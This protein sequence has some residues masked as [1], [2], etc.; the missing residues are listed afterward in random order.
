MPHSAAGWRIEPPVSV[1]S[2]TGRSGRHRGGRSPDGGSAAAVA[3]GTVPWWLGTDTGGSIRQPASLCGVA[4]LKPTYGAVS[5]YGMIAF[6][7]SL[8]RAGPL[9]VGVA[10][11]RC[12]ARHRRQGRVGLDLA[13]PARPRRAPLAGDLEGLGRRAERS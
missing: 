13:R 6:A 5:R 7:S 10:G 3:A 1:P 11:R 4:G 12:A 9:S 8:D 2:A